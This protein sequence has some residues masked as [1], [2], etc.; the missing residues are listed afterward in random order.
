M[1]TNFDQILAFWAMDWLEELT[2]GFGEGDCNPIL[3]AMPLPG[4]CIE[5]GCDGA[6]PDRQLASL[7]PRSGSPTQC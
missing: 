5:P 7:L 4:A 6:S 2:F 3:D 1:G